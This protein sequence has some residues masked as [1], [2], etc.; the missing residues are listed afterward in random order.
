MRHSQ[1]SDLRAQNF[2]RALGP[3]AFP[4]GIVSSTAG[5]AGNSRGRRQSARGLRG[6]AVLGPTMV[7][8][9]VLDLVLDLF[10]LVL[11]LFQLLL[12]GLGEREINSDGAA[13]NIEAEQRAALG[14]GCLRARVGRCG[15]AACGLGEEVKGLLPGGSGGADRR[16]RDAARQDYLYGQPPKTPSQALCDPANGGGT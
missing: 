16:D 12:D 5:R 14:G 6:R 13:S 1:N 4:N 9:L 3:Q 8:V 10:H 11:D 7:T 15:E 2:F